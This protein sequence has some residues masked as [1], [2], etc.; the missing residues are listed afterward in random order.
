MNS[1]TLPPLILMAISGALAAADTQPPRLKRADSFLGI[2]FDMHARKDCTAIGQNTTRA[3]IE[4]VID[5]VK[6]DYIQIDCKGHP[7]LSSYPTT[8]GHRAPGF[9]GDQ[10]ALWRQVTAEHGVAL[11][12]HYSGVWDEEAIRQHP[13]WA[14]INADGKPHAHAT[15]LFGPYVDRL[16]IPQLRELADVYRID[17]VWLD[18]ECWGAVPDYSPAAMAAFRSATGIQAT[19]CSAQDAGWQEF[20]A[21]H[22]EAFR[23]YLRHYIA[24]LK[25]T[26]PDLQLCSNWAFSD[27]MPEPV[28]APLDWLSGDYDKDDSVNSA[29]FSARYL[30]RQGKPWDLMAWSFSGPKHGR[31]VKSVPQLQREAACVLSLGGGF[32]AYFKQRRDASVQLDQMPLMAEVASFCRARQPFCHRSMPVPQVALLFSTANQHRRCN[33]L[34]QRDL[35][36][37]RGTLQALLESQQ[38]V[39]VLGEHTLTGRMAEYPLIVVPECDHLEPA[40]R[41]ELAAYARNGGSLLLIDGRSAA[42]FA[43][44]LGLTWDGETQERTATLDLEGAREAVTSRLRPVRVVQGRTV[45]TL[46]DATGVAHPAA[47]VMP[48]GQGRIAAIF[49]PFSKDYRQRR[50]PVARALFT[51]LV[52][53]LFPAPLVTVTGSPDVDVVVSR[54]DQRLTVQLVNTAGPH[55]TEPI[56]MDVPPVGP[57]EIAIRLPQAPRRI[58]LEPGAEVLPVTWRDGVARVTVQRLDIHRILIID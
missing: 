8:V 34:Y 30:A 13:D 44:E 14:A 25:R 50:P 6:P 12:M 23:R 29:R 32:Q 33:G 24:E 46:T 49:L 45:G 19:P 41:D 48:C 37:E 54:Q 52:R 2:H 42:L 7:G 3:M 27:H 56:V 38:S 11:Y 1:R 22:R 16:L 40:F 15:S 43:A 4:S 53:E 9:V 55:A 31:S 35:T 5:Q 21:F 57:L 58:V 10:L 39:E 47:T 36:L 20:H 28:S 18:G 51:S 26:N 17:G